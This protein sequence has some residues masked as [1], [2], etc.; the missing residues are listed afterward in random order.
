MGRIKSKYSVLTFQTQDQ[1]FGIRL[2]L[3]EGVATFPELVAVPGNNS[4]VYLGLSYV[5]G[6][7]MPVI[8]VATIFKLKKLSR[9]KDVIVL[10]FNHEYYAIEV[11]NIGDIISRPMVKKSAKTFKGLAT[12]YAAE[13][14][15]KTI[16]INIEDLLEQYVCS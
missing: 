12:T 6:Q 16:I 15:R 8:D 5:L 10:R 14:N 2:D 11:S 4:D 1:W 7:I 9:V 13:K 3:V